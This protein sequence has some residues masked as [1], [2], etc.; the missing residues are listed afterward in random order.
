ML[1]VAVVFSTVEKNTHTVVGKK[2]RTAE[3]SAIA[4]CITL[5]QLMT[6][7]GNLAQTRI[8]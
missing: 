4:V 6:S 8:Q 2:V 1:W 5:Q 3:I 7:P